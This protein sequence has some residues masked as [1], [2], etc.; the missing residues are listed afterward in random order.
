VG[1]V[2]N[3]AVRVIDTDIER[4][5]LTAAIDEALLESRID[6][7]S[8]D[9]IHLYRRR[10][11]SVSIGYFQSAAEVADLE[12]CH[13]DG[14]PVVRRISGGGAI[15]TDEGQLVYALITRP[16]RPMK[17]KQ[18]LE[19]VCGAVV[20]ALGRLG[21]E[22]AQMEGLNDV[23]VGNAKVSGSAQVIRKG[24]HLVHGTVLVDA[25]LEAMATYLR[26][27]GTKMEHRGHETPAAR[28]TTLKHLLG[29]APVMDEVKAAL[30]AEMA[31]IAG[32]EPLMGQLK[33]DERKRA[34]V[35]EKNRYCT[36]RWNLRR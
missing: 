6:G 23:V 28:V 14:I 12:A 36:D 5:Q 8:G 25:D 20:R 18:G 33:E 34:E 35:L 13:R 19:V 2:V 17:A 30:M 31:C 29:D 16:E 15:Y 22:G 32:G 21:I 1:P 10:P 4:P 27:Y 7:R 26:P 11:P 9:T 24:V 3:Q